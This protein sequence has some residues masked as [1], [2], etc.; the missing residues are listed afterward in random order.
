MT[1]HDFFAH[2]WQATDHHLPHTR[3]ARLGQLRLKWSCPDPTW[4][5]LVEGTVLSG[6]P[7]ADADFEVRLFGREML[8]LLPPLPI[9]LPK[10]SERGRVEEWCTPDF[11]T[12]APPN[13]LILADRTVGR[14]LVFYSALPDVP[15]WDLCAP[16]RVPLGFLGPSRNLHLLH[17]AAVQ[18]DKQALLLVG[19]GGS[20]KSSTALA[21]LDPAGPFEFITEDYAAVET[22]KLEVH[23]L[24]RSTKVDDSAYQRMPW[25]QQLQP[26]G[27]QEGK[28]CR[29]LSPE[30]PAQGGQ[31]RAL[32]WP[33]REFGQAMSRLSTAQA[34][35]ALAPSTL[36]QNPNSAKGDF[37]AMVALCRRLPCFR[38]GLADSPNPTEV[39][40]RLGSLLREACLVV[41]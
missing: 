25:L 38:L 27:R 28:D 41:R 10:V 17:G 32:V 18:K 21:C 26:L 19:K 40:Q 30:H 24:Y 11:L 23:P 35:K 4:G 15:I 8:P 16:L 14:A 39:Q 1:P 20:G 5:A 9:Q 12:V 31:L 37:K 6:P 34:L 3:C 29:V 22:E 13:S 7:L 2:A 36:F 33:D